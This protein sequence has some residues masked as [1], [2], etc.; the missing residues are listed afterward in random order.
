MHND[1]RASEPIKRNAER[2]RALIE[3]RAVFNGGRSTL[4]CQI[5][6][7]SATGARLAI[8][9][10]AILPPDEFLLVVPA[11]NKTYRVELSWRI[12][13][14]AGVRFLDEIAAVGGEALLALGSSLEELR[15]ENARLRRHIIE[16]KTK[17]AEL[18]YL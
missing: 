14:A 1:E 15:E 6:N 4:D 16:M 7:I 2:M 12:A 13:D 8:S 10:A 9:G 18:G 5:R 17:L 3:A 11:R